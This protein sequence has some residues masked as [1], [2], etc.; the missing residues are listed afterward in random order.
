MENKG[1]LCKLNFQSINEIFSSANFKRSYLHRI[2]I[3]DLNNEM[4]FNAKKSSRNMW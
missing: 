2:L 4:I 3:K 1:D